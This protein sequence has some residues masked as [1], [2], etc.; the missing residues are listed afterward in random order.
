MRAVEVKL[1]PK[2]IRDRLALRADIEDPRADSAQGNDARGVDKTEHGLSGGFQAQ[3]SRV[4]R[5]SC[6]RIEI[7]SAIN[8]PLRAFQS[9]AAVKRYARKN[10]FGRWSFYSNAITGWFQAGWK[11]RWFAASFGADC[12]EWRRSS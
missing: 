1:D 3:L 9:F 2:E 6:P 4:R 12:G 10:W 11:N 5:S 7:Q 8:Q